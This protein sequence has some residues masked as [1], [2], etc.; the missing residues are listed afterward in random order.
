MMGLGQPTNL[1][2]LIGMFRLFTFS[3]LIDQVR[4]E[5]VIVL[6]VFHLSHLTVA[7]FSPSGDLGQLWGSPDPRSALGPI[8]ASQTYGLHLE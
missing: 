6:S 5:S 3:G 4:F 2:L 7:P 8:G 1:C